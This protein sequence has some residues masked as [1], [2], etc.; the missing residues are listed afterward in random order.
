M[1]NNSE[2]IM[3]RYKKYLTNQQKKKL[4]ALYPGYQQT[5]ADERREAYLEQ[6]R[7]MGGYGE[8]A[9]AMGLGEGYLRRKQMGLDSSLDK[10]GRQLDAQADNAFEQA[11][12]GMANQT[13][14]ARNAARK[15]AYEKA[16]RDARAAD[17]ARK[18][19]KAAAIAETKK[20]KNE[21]QRLDRLNRMRN[22]R[23]WHGNMPKNQL[24]TYYPTQYEQENSFNSIPKKKYLNNIVYR[25]RKA[26]L[27]SQMYQYEDGGKQAITNKGQLGRQAAPKYVKPL[28]KTNPVGGT[29]TAPKLDVNPKIPVP[30]APEMEPEIEAKVK[31][32]KPEEISALTKQYY[33]DAANYY[34]VLDQISTYLKPVQEARSLVYQYQKNV[35]DAANPKLNVRDRLRAV[36]NAKLVAK[37]Y[38]AV[39][40]EYSKEML[41]KNT[42]QARL[43]MDGLKRQSYPALQAQREV[44]RRLGVTIS[45]DDFNYNMG[46]IAERGD[47]SP[48]L[49]DAVHAKAQELLEGKSDLAKEFWKRVNYKDQYPETWDSWMNENGFS[50]IFTPEVMEEDGMTGLA[51]RVK[52]YLQQGADDR[53]DY[54][55]RREITNIQKTL[56]S[57]PA[58]TTQR[59]IDEGEAKT[60]LTEYLKNTEDYDSSLFGKIANTTMNPGSDIGKN[61]AFEKAL[62]L[63]SGYMS[64]AAVHALAN[65][66]A[67]V[68]F[69]NYCYATDREDLAKQFI[70]DYV[71]AANAVEGNATA[72]KISALLPDN[73]KWI[74]EFMYHLG[75][76]ASTAITNKIDFF[77]GKTPTRASEYTSQGIVANEIER[78]WSEKKA[79]RY[80]G[81]LT[82]AGENLADMGIGMAVG[83]GL[84]AVAGAVGGTAGTVIGEVASHAPGALMGW[85]AA[86]RA[87]QDM[88]RKGYDMKT[89][90]AYG[91]FSGISEA[92]L[93]EKVGGFFGLGDHGAL[94][95]ALEGA[96]SDIP[97]AA[98]RTVV[99]MAL[100]NLSEIG[101]EEFGDILDNIYKCYVLHEDVDAYEEFKKQWADTAVTTALSTLLIG[102][103]GVPGHFMTEVS[104][105][106]AAK[107][108]GISLSDFRFLQETE[109][110]IR[111]GR[112]VK[113]AALDRFNALTAKLFAA[114]PESVVEQINKGEMKASDWLASREGRVLGSIN[115]VNEKL[116]EKIAKFSE[117][118]QTETLDATDHTAELANLKGKAKARYLIDASPTGKVGNLYFTTTDGKAIDV[119]NMG[120]KQKT[121]FNI[122]QKLAKAFPNIKIVAHDNL[123][124]IDGVNHVVEGQAPEIHVSLSGSAMVMTTAAHELL[125][126]VE[127]TDAKAYKNIQSYLAT[128]LDESEIATT[129]K[130]VASKYGIEYT[131]DEKGNKV[132]KDEKTQKTFESEVA[133]HLVEKV[134]TDDSF[135]DR[136]IR[137]SDPKNRTAR[138]KLINGLKDVIDRVT[139]ALR[140]EPTVS[141]KLYKLQ[142]T[143]EKAYRD[144]SKADLTA[145]K[146]ETEEADF[147]AVEKN[148]KQ[149]EEAPAT[150]EKAKTAKTR[151]AEIGEG[152]NLV[153]QK[154]VEGKSGTV[155]YGA[156][157]KQTLEFHY[158]AVNVNDL[159]TSHTLDGS[160]NDAYPAELQP[161][162]R[163][164]SSSQQ[165]IL[166][167]GNDIIP[168]KLGAYAGVQEGA[169]IIGQ[170]MIV[171]S[172][173]GRTIALRYA[174]K[175]GKLDNYTAWLK[176]HAS[177]FG[178]KAS[179][180]KD[181][182]VLVRVRDSAVDRAAFAK[183]ANKS[184]IATMNATER[185]QTD[186]DALESILNKYHFTEGAD[187]NSSANS[188]FF[189][190]FVDKVAGVNEAGSLL[191]S[192]GTLSN[193]G[194]T[195]I[196]NA[197]FELAYHDKTLTEQ[198]TEG[199]ENPLRNIIKAM[200]NVAPV[201]AKTTADIS[202][203][204][205]YAVNFADDIV[206]AEKFLKDLKHDPNMEGLRK[207][208]AYY[209]AYPSNFV[210]DNPEYLKKLEIAID[211][212]LRS[213]RSLS[214]LLNRII[215]GVQRLGSPNQLDMFGGMV[216][217]STDE[218]VNELKERI[219]DR[220]VDALE[221]QKQEWAEAK[222]Q[223]RI[224]DYPVTDAG[225]MNAIEEGDMDA[226]KE[227]L[228]E[229]ANEAMPN[230]KAVDKNGRLMRF[231]HGTKEQFN[232]FKRDKIGSTGRFE[233]SG[234]NF[235][236][237]EARARSYGGNVLSGYIDIQKPL[238]ASKKTITVQQLAKI[239]RETDP[240]GDNIIAN[241]AEN[242]NDYGKPSFI[243]RE[244]LHAARMIWEYADSDVDIYSD[245]SSADPDAEGLIQAFEKLGYDGLIHYDTNGNIKTVVTFNSHQ[246]KLADVTYDDNGDIIPLSER[247]NAENEDIR[248]RISDYSEDETIVG[249]PID[250]AAV[251]RAVKTGKKQTTKDG[252]TV[253]IDTG[254]N[255]KY[256]VTVSRDG[257]V[258][259][260]REG[261]ANEELK[262]ADIER[263]AAA[264]M[265][266]I[267]KGRANSN[268]T[269]TSDIYIEKGE[270]PARDVNVPKSARQGMKTSK[271]ARTI[272]EAPGMT[273]ESVDE[274]MN[275]VYRGFM[276]YKPD[277]N[278]ESMDKALK[279]IEDNMAEAVVEWN[280]VANSGRILTPDDVAL[281]SA[282]MVSASQSG[283]V[284]SAMEIASQLQDL[285]TTGGKLVQSFRMIKR[286]GAAGAFYYVNRQVAKINAELE[287]QAKGYK[288]TLNE[289][290]VQ[291]L[292]NARDY[293]D[294]R[295]AT[296]ALRKDLGQQLKPTLRD[297]LTA[298][299]YTAM[300]GNAKT[301]VRNDIGNA[302]YVPVIMMD[303]VLNAIGQTVTSAVSKGKF[304]KTTKLFAGK[305]YRNFANWD[306]KDTVKYDIKG[307]KY[308]EGQLGDIKDYMRYDTHAKGILKPGAWVFEKW[309]SGTQKFM[310]D[311]AKL[312]DMAFK[313]LHYQHALAT[314]LDQ[315]KVDVKALQDVLTRS[316]NNETFEKGTRE[317]KL[318]AV[319]EAAAQYAVSEA[320]RNTYN[321]INAFA[322]FVSQMSRTMYDKEVGGKHPLRPL[323]YALEGVLPFKNTPANIVARAAEHSPI[324]L[325][326]TLTLDIGRVAKG[327]IS[328]EQ[329]IHNLS[330][331][332]TGSALFA[333]GAILA[334]A[335]ILHGGL[336]YD[337]KDDKEKKRRGHQS[338]SLEIGNTSITLDWL[339][340]EC[341]P[342][343]M[344]VEL[345][346]QLGGMS[347]EDWSEKGLKALLNVTTGA[348]EP[349]LNMSMLS[350]IN[351]LFEG[352]TSTDDLQG[353][354]KVA[355]TVA[356]SYLTQF[357]PTILG[358]FARTIDPT[359]RTTY[360]D[361]NAKIPPFMQKF[362][363]TALKKIP[364]ATFLLQP[365]VDE[366]G[367]T[368]KT[369]E[370]YGSGAFWL[371]MAEQF[372]SPA[373]RSKLSNTEVDQ[374]IE[375]LGEDVYP[376]RANK[377]I[378][379]DKQ[380]YNLSADEYTAYATL[381]GE[382][383]YALVQNMIG[384]DA[385]NALSDAEK[386]AAFKDAYTYADTIAK[387][388]IL[389]M[390]GVIG[391]D[392][393]T[394]ESWVGKANAYAK[395]VGTP[396]AISQF[397]AVK[398][399]LKVNGITNRDDRAQFLWQQDIPAENKALLMEM[400]DGSN[401]GYA[402]GTAFYNKKGELVVDFG[403][404]RPA[405]D[406]APTAESEAATEAPSSAEVPAVEDK[407]A[408]ATNTV[409]KMNAEESTAYLNTTSFT[410]EEK[411]Q[412]LANADKNDP[413]AKNAET[414]H[415]TYGLSYDDM[416]D[417]HSKYNSET[418][419]GY[420]FQKYVD[421]KKGLKGR[422]KFAL[423]ELANTQSAWFEK[424]QSIN[425]KMGISYDT[426]WKIKLYWSGES[427]QGKKARI[428][429]YCKSLGLKQSQIDKLYNEYKFL[430]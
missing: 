9:S 167:I 198:F 271:L 308:S 205:L 305:E 330:S 327:K 283:D 427:G 138:A 74:P 391:A 326:K 346:E 412:I 93:Q 10:Y 97:S 290:L 293:H 280:Q 24:L 246:F 372:F 229:A 193:E 35:Q 30:V 171:E 75:Y 201:V 252:Y 219:V 3:A 312:G 294:I 281:G 132:F 423:V 249:T 207:A 344:G 363:Q 352:F 18:K 370:K 254:E 27:D 233:G 59:L 208:E 127:K 147:E 339:A 51:Q 146:T 177:D 8:S 278:Q 319:Y 255:N 66:K 282:L 303:N 318:L 300:L 48:Q 276:S 214:F 178:L 425:S 117:G 302:A 221:K 257:E 395:A 55:R 83:G 142:R 396:D 13:I 194:V 46:Y 145:T 36:E 137:D 196:Q 125:H 33:K 261:V 224:G 315:L 347:A 380:K 62:G 329:F 416:W 106:S 85:S 356:T 220:A 251:R 130:N 157:N 123:Y 409:K 260:T 258:I 184:T 369:F 378:N 23:T 37:Q 226:A 338:Y 4:R 390:R 420:D 103:F 140:G 250:T 355:A 195:R 336:G 180:I 63:P 112:R 158:A 152:E 331:G 2:G 213:Q 392:P 6:R 227:I 381:R 141:G 19:A 42:Q 95:K 343:F 175:N 377:Y 349:M 413:R 422:Q 187:F 426:L 387:S 28:K 67:S 239:I 61:I 418:F 56:S 182:T 139:K 240:T 367:N 296:E 118:K 285:A 304:E 228:E 144:I 288:L 210:E 128:L 242:T 84:G 211:N 129:E 317:A 98:G 176:D 342:L 89:A 212:N 185:A 39:V 15:K 108:A 295:E 25:N 298:W 91:I 81:A 34:T 159:V 179:D 407:Y 277:V 353:I 188:E 114:M 52:L 358:Q 32:T 414:F 368:S 292:L 70:F 337:D 256:T 274:L 116:D 79:T 311:E 78:G 383:A 354:E 421:G 253:K 150:E 44:L 424:A 401:G 216:D 109:N 121:N 209:E 272:A 96:V 262:G 113:P 314:R 164:R 429:A 31:A 245:I 406:T 148:E 77:R 299:R 172:G 386:V 259:N 22:N 131:V 110:D 47:L 241:Y 100:D 222:N 29:V 419:H 301:L 5:M 384:T 104:A 364:G 284:N 324:G 385:Y 263:T 348:F 248:Y 165:Q 237:S 375:R 320:N 120:L 200:L 102:S 322:S 266:N 166:D 430:S 88:L 41:N 309:R 382:T 156:G 90:T 325:A 307:N 50:W 334:K 351:A 153:A 181:N 122:A 72:D 231:Y 149:K 408:E 217:T 268:N 38:D 76:G 400:N 399:G 332:L 80:Q 197:L 101:Q 17:E 73:W 1:A 16:V 135:L 394:L 373:Y 359:R 154:G 215:E 306:W 402:E 230:S 65:D 321:D 238:S 126:Q 60:H 168:D 162:D 69:I 82:S 190:A 286:L 87:K 393:G 410:S 360:Y 53:D 189:S 269:S 291:N 366:F 404:E 199:D 310:E 398:Q 163:S 376:S 247:F 107:T 335:G 350:G 45:E 389:G 203:G 20:R 49:D 186:A 388:T 279:K 99:N 225:Y 170:D 235:T 313:K 143:I 328:G 26:L 57:V 270:N 68:A 54:L 371:N 243:N 40:P 411:Y 244:S 264:L 218:A 316:R 43:L 232:E 357:Q 275:K 397:I 379:F 160:I 287:K 174:A 14:K 273:D 133:A 169:P 340:P 333:L 289:E 192:R 365:Y 94:T 111:D 86:G 267:K 415:A 124:G 361:K 134:L 7:A 204:D 405:I 21:L 173:N 428:T 183:E 403:G 362:W 71:E 341:I 236:P 323:H 92:V 119:K 105:G 223:W 136:I 151:S 12:V 234:F 206:A 191:T 374:E 161:R 345:F 58:E 297:W 155:R 265:R 202:N 115:R 64:R 11:T 417:V